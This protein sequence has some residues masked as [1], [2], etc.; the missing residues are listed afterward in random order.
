MRTY[1]CPS[2]GAPVKFASGAAVFAVCEHCRS[3]VVRS[4]VKL[5]AIG[6]MA[7]LPPDLSPL[8]IGST[9][10]WQGKAFTLLGR[11]RLAWSDGSWTEWYSVF[12]DGRRGWIAETQG[13]FT[14]SFLSEND[15]IPQ[16]FA[17][18][19]P[20]STV[21]FARNRWRVMDIKETRVVAAE[22][23]LPFVAK[24][25]ATRYGIDFAGQNGE[26]GG[27][28]REDGR[29]VFYEGAY[30]TFND[31]NFQNL[32][33]VPG[34]SD[35][36][37]EPIR[38]RT[39]S[40]SCPHCG[41]PVS[42]RAEG[43][44][45]S[46]VCGSCSTIVDTSQPDAQ[47]V[48]RAQA[49]QEKL[50]PIVPLGARGM[51]RGTL[52]E[53]IGYVVRAD[54]YAS[55]S[56]Y[57]LFNPWHG[58]VWLVTYQGHWS[59]V[60]RLL[61]PPQ[62]VDERCVV[63]ERRRFQLYA[64]SEAK[65]T[66][67]LGEFYWRVSRGERAKVNDYV[68]PPYVLSNEQYPDLQEQTWSVGEYVQPDEV[69]RAFNLPSRPLGP[70]GR[71]LNE[72]NP[73][74]PKIVGAITI[75]ALAVAAMLAIEVFFFFARSERNLA[76]ETY[77]FRPGAGDAN[78]VTTAPFA[79]EGPPQP[80]HLSAYAP[81]NNAWLDVNFELVNADT[82]ETRAGDTEISFYSG[83]DSDGYWTEG[84]QRATVDLPSVPPGKYFLRVE[85]AGEPKGPEIQYSINA[86]AGGMFWS[87]FFFSVG[88]VLIYPMWVI[89]R[90][91][92]FE[93]DRWAESDYSPYAS[94]SDDDDD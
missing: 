60:R 85:A 90:N 26:F 8:Q 52:Y 37:V 88:L 36:V 45:M 69:V 30:A 11:V 16:R 43:L 24:P 68:A 22:G 79:I 55:W 92:T 5:E 48:Q 61:T 66:G 44:T 31:L 80:V 32:K 58:F 34:W 27:L 15:S 13:F 33:P 67:V 70:Y 42:L 77:R 84:S 53:V 40:L 29:F 7:E 10:S 76:S 38:R 62:R 12:N 65:V 9:G 4:D 47:V 82:G 17:E 74:A 72:P 21:D 35:A 14:V 50:A 64:D 57:L 25:G 81:I 23:E 1:E 83:R 56:E 63:H 19:R 46:V 18:L 91:F 20:G 3:M 54:K 51:L 49:E 6:A 78:E 93:R 94:S 86:S 71:Y 39:R 75:G 59:L 28:E 41:A 87:N 2:C 73:Y 89:W